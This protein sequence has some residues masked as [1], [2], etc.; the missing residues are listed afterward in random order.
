MSIKKLDNGQYQV[1]VRPAGMKGKRYRKRFDRKTEA[2]NY[3][4]FVTTNFH[5]KDWRE[6]PSDKRSLSELIELWFQLYGQTLKTGIRE[7]KRLLRIDRLMGS[8]RAYQITKQFFIRHRASRIESGVQASTFNRDHNSLSSVF[9]ALIDAGEYPREHPLTGISKLRER[10]SEMSFLSQ[11]EIQQL[12]ASL[13]E[14]SELIARLCLCTGARWGEASDLRGEQVANGR[15]TFLDTKNNKNRTIPIGDKLNTRLKQK[16]S[17]RLFKS[18]Y[19]DFYA[20]LKGLEFNL[21]KGQ[22][23]HVLRHTFAS[24]FMMNGGNI[25]TLQK[26]LGHSD[27][28]HTLLY[29]HFSPDHLVDAIRFNPLGE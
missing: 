9:T 12:L 14:D 20:V 15:V 24:H 23:S 11:D 5:D 4:R 19:A 29:A 2:T 6:K 27:I 28:K 10:P 1:D 22:A 21:P 17:G 25:L 18:S 13:G 16:G 26:I 3:E 7:R 8:P